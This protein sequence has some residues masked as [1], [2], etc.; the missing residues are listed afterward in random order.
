MSAAVVQD[1]REMG[2]GIGFRTR[3][4][5]EVTRVAAP[6]GFFVYA[7]LHPCSVVTASGWSAARAHPGQRVRGQRRAV[8]ASAVVVRSRH[9]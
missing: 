8:P 7:G 2:C 3:L 6:G 5:E 9:S 1:L 4:I